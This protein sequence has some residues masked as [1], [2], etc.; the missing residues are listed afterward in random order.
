MYQDRTFQID[1]IESSLDVVSVVASADGSGSP[2]SA[3]TLS[4]ISH[5]TAKTTRKL[6]GN[7]VWFTA[8][9]WPA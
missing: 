5:H 2:A 1:Q 7:R 3:S 9:G 8:F 6:Q 4:D